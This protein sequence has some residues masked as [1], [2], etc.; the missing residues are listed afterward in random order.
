MDSR[1]RTWY[2]KPTDLEDWT[3]VEP[4][5]A[6]IEAH[7]IRACCHLARTLHEA[8]LIEGAIG[9]PVPVIVHELEYYDEIAE[10]NRLANPDGLADGL[11]RWIEEM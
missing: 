10:Q 2:E 1:P 4:L 8:K 3:T 11:V 5:A 7:F 9:R 6:Q